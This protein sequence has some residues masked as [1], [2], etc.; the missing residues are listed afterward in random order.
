MLSVRVLPVPV[1]DTWL[2]MVAS[3]GTTD[4]TSESGLA[5]SS[6]SVI[7]IGGIVRFSSI[8]MLLK[9]PIV[10]GVFAGGGGGPGGA[11][12][13]DGP[14]AGGGPCTISITESVVVCAVA[15]V[16]RTVSGNDPGESGMPVSIPPTN[17][18][19]GGRTPLSRLNES[20]PLPVVVNW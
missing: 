9:P 18:I 5:E 6:A 7:A 14:G 3:P 16:T 10:G 11:G 20:A 15:S 12:S 2:R 19:P 4:T 8:V 13:G 17:V 1:S